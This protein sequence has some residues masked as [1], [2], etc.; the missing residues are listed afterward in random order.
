MFIFAAAA[1]LIFGL[2]FLLI[3]N[4]TMSM[5]GVELNDAGQ[6]IARYLGATF[7]GLTVL[8][9]LVRNAPAS[10]TRRAVVLG[11]FVLS[12]LGLVVAVWDR[13]AGSGNALVWLTVAIYLVLTAGFGYFQ[14]MKPAA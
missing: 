13:I 6:W 14:F 9:W 10:D 1:G 4:Q 3:P 11:D 2:G 12:A 7:L 5:Y 8:N